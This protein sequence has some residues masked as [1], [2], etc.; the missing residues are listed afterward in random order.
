MKHLTLR[1]HHPDLRILHL[2]MF[3]DDL[4][5][6]T[7]DQ[8]GSTTKPLHQ[9]IHVNRVRG[10]KHLVTQPQ[11]DRRTRREQVTFLLGSPV[12]ADLQ[13]SI[14]TQLRETSVRIPLNVKETRHPIPERHPVTLTVTEH[15]HIHTPRQVV[16]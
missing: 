9:V 14:V 8:V 10:L 2:P 15:R 3:I 13:V 5:P 6:D 1:P 11:A 4:H 12:L 7:R 16:R